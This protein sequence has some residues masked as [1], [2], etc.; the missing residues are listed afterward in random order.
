MPVPQKA[1]YEFLGWYTA[2]NAEGEKYE[3]GSIY[4]NTSD[5]TLYAAWRATPFAIIYD[6]DG[7][8]NHAGNPREYVAGQT[9]TLQA[10]TK[11]GY[12]FIGWELDG[13][14]LDSNQISGKTGDLHL[15]A[16]WEAKS[17]A[18]GFDSKGSTDY[19]AS[20]VGLAHVT[21]GTD[22]FCF[23]IP[24]RV[25][26][27]FLGW[28]Y[29]GIAFTDANGNAVRKWDLPDNTILYAVWEAESF[30]IRYDAETGS[31]YFS[32]AAWTDE[33]VEV[34]V[35]MQ[36]SNEN[37]VEK[38]FQQYYKIQDK[39][40]RYFYYLKPNG[41]RVTFRLSGTS[42]PFLEAINGTVEFFAEYR[43][44]EHTLIFVTNVQGQ[45]FTSVTADSG[46]SI[47]NEL[48]TR[49]PTRKG[50]TFGGW[51]ITAAP[52]NPALEGTVLGNI[53]PDCSSEQVDSNCMVEAIWNP[54]SVTIE[55]DPNGG[56]S[57][58]TYQATF[59]EEFKLPVPTRVGY[60][61]IG[62]YDANNKQ[63]TGSTG[64]SLDVLKETELEVIAHWSIIRYSITYVLNGG[65]NHSSNPSSYSV[66]SH[67]TLLTP[68]RSGYRFMGWYT[69]SNFNN[70]ITRTSGTGN[71]TVYAKWSKLYTI[72]ILDSENTIVRTLI[73]VYNEVFTLPTYTKIGFDGKYRDKH[74]GKTYA[75]G[76]KYIVRTNADLSIVWT[77]TYLYGHFLTGIERNCFN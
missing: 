17:I 74:D 41:D 61:F 31:I 19:P 32:G 58:S 12:T 3:N 71:I 5:F 13:T 53:M 4:L 55:L 35:G 30:K 33:E 64:E 9:I 38:T 43:L 72:K 11:T 23:D 42:M 39:I 68:Q 56:S 45:S 70:R 28:Y 73:G 63:Y 36:L 2:P 44:E 65:K 27:K 77:V 29:N 37:V 60:S 26:F 46:S 69:D 66:V 1:G 10:P 18:V 62:W 7:G 25:G 14:M 54:I 15:K 57:V 59:G 8:T 34:T 49:I 67:V 48:N 22:N 47:V 16:I 52:D 40:I 76:D 20:S 21:Y 50:Y 75:F 24:E 51:K 6:M